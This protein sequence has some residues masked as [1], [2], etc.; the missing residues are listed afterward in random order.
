VTLRSFINT[1]SARILGLSILAALALF[2]FTR[3]EF[4]QTLESKT[5]DLRFRS[6]PTPADPRIVIVTVD[7]GSLETRPWLSWP[8]P[9]ELFGQC[10]G[11]MQRW[12]AD[13][14]A[15]DMIYDLPSLYGAADDSSLGRSAAEFGRAAFG[16]A[17][18]TRDGAPVPPVA[19]VPLDGDLS[20]LDSAWS[21]APPIGPILDGVAVLGSVS[22]L[23]DSDGVYRRASLFTR[24]PQG[25][26]PSL[27]VAAAWISAGRPEMR[28]SADEF[29][30]GDVRLPLD[31][32]ANLRMRFRGPTG[33]FRYIPI[34]ALLE[35]LDSIYSG[36]PPIIDST[37]FED[38]IVLVGVTAP[39]LY[40]LKPTPYSAVCPGVEVHATLIDNLLSGE[41]IYRPGWGIS[42]ASGLLV[43]LVCAA[44]LLLFRSMILKGLVGLAV[45]AGWVAICFGLFASGLWLEMLYPAASGVAAVLGGTSLFYTHANRQRKQIRAA[46]S[47]YLSPTVV[48]QLSR[49]PEQLKLGGEQRT[50]TAHFSDLQGFTSFSE[51]LSPEELVHLLNRYLTLMTDII[52]DSGGT[53]DK[54]IGDAV[55]AFWNAPLALEDH[56]ARACE[57]VLRMR[58]GLIG[59][60]EQLRQEGGPEL[61]PRT[62]LNTGPMTVGNM[63][64]T[65]RFDYTMMGSAVNLASRLEG[66]NKAYG[67]YIMVSEAT[68][69]AAG[70]G[71]SFRELDLIRVVGQ[72]TPVRIFELLGLDGEVPE[73]VLKRC[74]LYEEALGLYRDGK[75]QAAIRAFGGIAGDAPS[76]SMAERSSRFM[77]DG[78]KYDWDGVY[79]MTSK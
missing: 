50:M 45:L 73:D 44:G 9:R 51:K 65:R 18:L 35:S 7:G 54:Y 12:G 19:V 32:N 33:T 30:F 22:A 43:S 28:I 34:A 29:V 11:L 42:L 40:D 78:V 58:N 55:V 66:V 72:K 68:R 24:T 41:A 17:L 36:R 15:F 57:A 76:A 10:L 37:L 53:L 69:A 70:P 77:A 47:Q 21:A 48:E 3:L 8:W 75:F 62:G 26:V 13:V 46:F 39:G 2:P 5:L 61:K 27:A 67:S 23:P 6:E 14:V 60:N 74:R 16:T 56:A 63:G 25:V 79:D 64:S 59:L 4:M 38:A 1:L 71:F 31:G 52:L 49:H 20:F